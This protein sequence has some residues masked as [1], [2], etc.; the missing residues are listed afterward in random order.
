M[1]R[2]STLCY[3]TFCLLLWLFI[4]LFLLLLH[5]LLLFEGS[6]SLCFISATGTE[7]VD[8]KCYTKQQSTLPLVAQLRYL[9]ITYLSE[10]RAYISPFVLQINTDFSVLQPAFW[11][12]I[13]FWDFAFHSSPVP[14]ITINM[15]TSFFGWLII[16]SEMDFPRGL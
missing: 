14:P 16:R 5:L 1:G 13:L 12:H 9:K 10:G 4:H 11:R 3:I 7:L 2:W 15:L 8:V 6:C